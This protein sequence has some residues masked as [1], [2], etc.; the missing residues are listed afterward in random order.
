MVLIQCNLTLQ[1]MFNYIIIFIIYIIFIILIIFNMIKQPY[2]HGSLIVMTEQD[3]TINILRW[4]RFN[5]NLRYR[6]INTISTLSF[7]L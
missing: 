4:Y 1:Y 3:I 7:L 2:C 5:V 6:Y